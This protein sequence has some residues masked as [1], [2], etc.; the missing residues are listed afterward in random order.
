MALLCA[1]GD[2]VL[3]DVDAQA[4]AGGDGDKAVRVCEHGS[5]GQCNA[6]ATS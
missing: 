6:T 5:I 4:G 2:V 1:F 3:V